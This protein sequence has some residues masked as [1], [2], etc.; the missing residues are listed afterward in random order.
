M[1][2]RST[3]T[4]TTPSSNL[5]VLS[6]ETRLWIKYVQWCTILTLRYLNSALLYCVFY[7]RPEYGT[8]YSRME[9]VKFEVIWS[10]L[11]NSFYKIVQLFS[12]NSHWKNGVKQIVINK[13]YHEAASF[14]QLLKNSDPSNG[15]KKKQKRFFG[16]WRTFVW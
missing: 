14:T 2:K 4:E 13:N 15:V 3:K 9:Q 5:C 1:R 12:S 8:V 7:S 10:V 16:F 11:T 6:L